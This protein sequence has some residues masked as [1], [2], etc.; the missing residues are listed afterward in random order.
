VNP[1]YP[2]VSQ[3]ASNRCEYCRAPGAIANFPFEV[4]HI[5][6]P[7]QGGTQEEDNLA[8]AC[9]S[10][11]IFKSDHLTADDPVTAQNV[12]LFHPRRDLWHEHFT[13]DA[14][15]GTV[16]GVTAIGRATV[17]LLRMNTAFQRNARLLW[18]QLGI[19]P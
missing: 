9:R 16:E 13:F 8:L 5:V 1:R 11:N 3:R 15:Q 19:Y 7:G 2:S 12:S 14:E 4:E 10:C 18:V 17:T 6:P